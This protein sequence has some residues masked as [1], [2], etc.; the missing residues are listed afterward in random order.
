MLITSCGLA[1]AKSPEQ[2][3]AQPAAVENRYEG[4]ESRKRANHCPV[5]FHCATS[6][7]SVLEVFFAPIGA[8][9]LI[10]HQYGAPRKKAPCLRTIQLI[11]TP[12]FSQRLLGL[13]CAQPRAIQAIWQDTMGRL[14]DLL[15]LAQERGRELGLPYA[16]AL[17]PQEA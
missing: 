12:S 10:A 3:P 14:T 16:G 2:V 4:N 6:Q 11:Y 17:T 7:L 5:D 13:Y 8:P 9:N 1:I 15:Q